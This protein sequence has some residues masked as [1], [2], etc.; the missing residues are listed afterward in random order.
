MSKEEHFQDSFKRIFQQK[1]DLKTV[2][3]MVLLVA[4]AVLVSNRFLPGKR[5]N[6]NAA[7]VD[8]TVTVTQIAK[9]VGPSI[10]GI[11]MTLRSTILGRTLQYR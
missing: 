4:L 11:R 5:N 7:L 2:L 6:L 10:V 1:L 8:N 3:I 9:K